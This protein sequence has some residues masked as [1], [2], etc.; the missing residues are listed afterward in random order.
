MHHDLHTSQGVKTGSHIVKHNAHAFAKFFDAAKR[1]RLD[2]IEP[3]KK[4][5]AQQ[6][7]FPRHWCADEGNELACHF[8]NHHKLRIFEG[9]GPTDAG[10]SGYPGRDSQA[11]EKAR[12]GGLPRRTDPPRQEPPQKHRRRRGPRAWARMNAPDPEERGDQRSPSRSGGQSRRDAGATV[13]RIAGIILRSRRFFFLF[14]SRLRQAGE[15]RLHTRR[16]PIYRGRS[17]DSARCRTET[18]G[19]CELPA[20]CRWGSAV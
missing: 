9:R 4:Y 15:T 7:R 17:G 5:K 10:S 1:R 2:D 14:Q 13:G 18:P 20:F 11:G 12:R 8:V 3:A 16:W 19:P 6:L